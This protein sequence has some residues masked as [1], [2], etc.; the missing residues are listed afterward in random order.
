[1]RLHCFGVDTE[2]VVHVTNGLRCA[3]VLPWWRMT[4]HSGGLG[5]GGIRRNFMLLGQNRS[6]RKFRGRISTQYLSRVRWRA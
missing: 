1:M 6:R 2:A 5:A 4:D 3:K